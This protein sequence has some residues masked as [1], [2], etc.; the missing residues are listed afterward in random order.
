VRSA[1][2]DTVVA[3]VLTLAAILV[4]EGGASAVLFL[5]ALGDTRAPTPLQR[6]RTVPDTLLGWRNERSAS[7]PDAY[8]KGIGLY[9]A[10]N[11]YRRQT[12]SDT[13]AGVAGPATI[14]CSGDS[15]TLGA[16]VN[17]DQTWCALLERALPGTRTIN[18]G[19]ESYG[20][21]QTYLLYRSEG[22][23]TPH[24]LQILAVTNTALERLASGDDAGWP[25]PKLRIENGA[26][27]TDGVP[28]S[29]PTPGGYRRTAIGRL[30]GDLRVVQALR[31]TPS[32]DPSVERARAV[33]AHRPIVE[34]LVAELQAAHRAAGSRLLLVYLPAQR[35]IA[36]STLDERRGWLAGAAK[37][38]GV[39]FVDLTPPL[40]AMGRD[41]SDV[42][43]FA[44]WSP[45][46]PSGANGQLT[47]FGHAW[48]AQ[49]LAGRV[50]PAVAQSAPA[51]PAPASNR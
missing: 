41:S 25:K 13:V 33:D 3:V 50:A 38:V 19:Q 8:G 9:T 36:D 12:T 47:T 27:A 35:E 5:G 45:V 30:V 46:Q 39:D 2:G 23:R 10:V 15:Y 18:M 20:L 48:V 11:G 22:A 16:G 51:A 49:M 40:R 34:R 44:R 7:R 17:G 6:A 31:R 1:I 43:Y 21:D 29:P 26:L 24:G 4:L 14:A 42:A 28:V 37:R 32:F